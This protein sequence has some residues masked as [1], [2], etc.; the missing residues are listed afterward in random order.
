[1]NNDAIFDL[2]NLNSTEYDDRVEFSGY[3]S[4]FDVLD[5]HNDVILKGA[6]KNIIDNIPLL[7]QHEVNNPIGKITLAKEDDFGLFIEGFI[8]KKTKKANEAIELVNQ[9][10]LGNL[11]IG[12]FVKKSEEKNNVNYVTELELKEISLVSIPANQETSITLKTAMS[13]KI[14]KLIRILR[15]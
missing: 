4:V 5:S 13:G 10:V 12:Y 7:W 3:A 11:S 15:S 9:G 8:T 14:E 1:M 6:F 2:S